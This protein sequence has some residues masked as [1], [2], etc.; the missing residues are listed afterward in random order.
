[1]SAAADVAAS[2]G[3]AAVTMIFF[4]TM[5]AALLSNGGRG[6]WY[7]GVLALAVFAIFGLT[8]FLLPPATPS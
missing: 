8:L 1:L 3:R 4:A 6:A 5:A 7:V 2:S